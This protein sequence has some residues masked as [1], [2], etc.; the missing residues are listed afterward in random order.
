MAYECLGA[1]QKVAQVVYGGSYPKTPGRTAGQIFKVY[2]TVFQLHQMLW[3]LRDASTII[4]AQPLYTEIDALI[5]EN[6]TLTRLSPD[7]ILNA[8]IGTYK[9]KV[10]R[11]LIKTGELVQLAAGGRVESRHTTDFIGKD[12]KRADLSGKD[13]SL[14]LLIAADLS[15]CRLYGANFLGADMRDANIEDADLSQSVFLTQM[16]INTA[17]GNRG[18]KL[19]PTLSRPASW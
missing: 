17:A 7:E 3:Y 4:S 6:Y 11:I 8:D 1:G 14:S 10:D 16:Q 18:T 2:P 5:N 12:F 13:F 9:R 15:G 19:P